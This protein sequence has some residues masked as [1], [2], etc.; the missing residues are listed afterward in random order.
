MPIPNL[1]RT[2]KNFQRLRQIINVFAKH[3]FGHIIDQMNLG[4]YGAKRWRFFRVRRFDDD[5]PITPLSVP[6]RLRLAFEE[7]GPT[8]IKLGQILSTRPDLIS[9]EW[10]EELKKLQSHASSFPFSEVRRIIESE[11]DSPFEGI[12]ADFN[13]VPFA[14]ASMAQ[15]HDATL[16]NGDAVVVKVQRPDIAGLINTD[17][18]LLAFLARLL[19]K[20]V[21]ES[22]L[23][24]PTELI[25]EFARSIRQEIDFTMEG[26]STDYF[27][28]NFSDNKNIKIPKIYWEFT[29][30]RVLTLERI[31]GIPIDAIQKLDA[32]EIDRKKI[33]EILLDFFYKQIFSDGFFHSDPHPGNLFVLA[34]GRIG[35]VDFGMA[36]R[37]SGE[38]LHSICTWFVAVLN[39]DVDRVV[40]TY[41]RMGILG[42][43][44][45]TAAL[46][47]EM[48]DFLDRYF[49][50]PL[51]RVRISN[52]IDEVFN[53][54]LR[55]QVQFPSAFLM[56]GKTVVTIESV[57]M[58][59]NPDFNLLTFS[60]PYISDLVVQQ[61]DAQHWAKQMYGT[62]EDFAEMARDLPLQ[63]HQILQKLQKGNLKLELE[64]TSLDRLI[65]EFDRVS[66]RIAFSLIIAA[67]IIGSSI[68]LQHAEL[69]D[70]RWILGVMGYLTA[71]F[72][73][74]GLVI[75]ILRS[76]RF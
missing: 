76:G 46:K 13:P 44:T 12:F 35:L 43:A 36:G 32:A 61:F 75:S 65:R 69:L 7:L 60:Q 20:H 27:H 74:V 68:I 71:G 31:D 67:L 51:S 33:A 22:R 9:A 17:L 59:L 15:V 1:N 55:H 49:N 4:R 54:S 63:L 34:D 48:A 29:N 42:D 19:E 16:Q 66:N 37:I 23:Y 11:L 64:H 41:V 62:I 3:G 8:F 56:L 39:R 70:Y 5:E 47:M 53:A 2:L 25:R 72:F 26:A 30:R 38:M 10:I 45:N 24:Q 58:R 57:V 18:N 6:E 50:M 40:K 21:V 14:A 52:L 73:G 28:Q